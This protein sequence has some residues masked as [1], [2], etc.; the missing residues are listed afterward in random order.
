MYRA[1]RPRPRR[2]TTAGNCALVLSLLLSF[3]CSQP[4]PSA[5]TMAQ[6]TPAPPKIERPTVVLPD[7][8]VVELELAITPLEVANGLMYRPSLPETRGMLFVFEDD[9]IPSFWMKN[10]L[11]SLDMVF[12]DSSGAVVDIVADVPPCATDPCPTYSPD[13]PAR[14]VLEL[15]AGGAA[16][17]GIEA[18]TT[19]TFDGLAAYPVLGEAPDSTTGE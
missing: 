14:A 13:S 7:G 5:D 8:F 1:F 4:Q 12:L 6:P 9:R 17:H 11:I 16:T 19:L 18:G 2:V 3:G 10:T 15:A